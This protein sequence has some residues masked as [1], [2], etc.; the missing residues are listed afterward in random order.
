MINLIPF[1]FEN[2]EIRT[3]LINNT[4]WFAAADVCAVLDIK[5]HRDSVRHL[6]D[7]EKG[8]VSTD[9][10]GGQQ[11]ITVV[12]ESGLYSLVLRSRK[13]EARKFAKWV[14][15]E[16]LP[17]IR[18]TGRYGISAPTPVVCTLPGHGRY[19]VV[20]DHSGVRVF[21]AAG[22]TMLE[23]DLHRALRR[24]THMLIAAMKEWTT[25]ALITEGD[26]S[27][28]QL[29]QPLQISFSM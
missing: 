24:D 16:V 27:P 14:T 4:A 26:V 2:H 22:K 9:T 11:K 20:A 17:S 23:T 6:D 19:L 3:T 25:R 10:L 5:N 18:K 8:V 15:S 21:D 7:D 28:K 12:N 1:S 13:P 29:E